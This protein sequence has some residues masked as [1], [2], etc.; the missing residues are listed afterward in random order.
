MAAGTK[1]QIVTDLG[2]VNFAQ[3]SGGTQ[4]INH[5][6]LLKIKGPKS[7]TQAGA[8]FSGLD[9]YFDYVHGAIP[10]AHSTGTLAYGPEFVSSATATAATVK[11][12]YR[13]FSTGLRL[14]ASVDCISSVNTVLFFGEAVS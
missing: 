8:L 14:T 9:T 12:L 11:M 1:F 3:P 5:A 7:N 4:N 2:R 6:R 13:R 10:V